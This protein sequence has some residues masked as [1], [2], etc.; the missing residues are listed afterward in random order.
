LLTEN[1]NGEYSI[2]M[3]FN[4][5]L[6]PDDLKNKVLSFSA[7]NYRIGRNY[8][9]GPVSELGPYFTHGV[10]TTREFAQH[11]ISQGG[12]KACHSI[13]SQLA[14]REFFQEVWEQKDTAIF[15]DLKHPQCPVKSSAFPAAFIS[16]DC[17]IQVIDDAVVRLYS[18]GLMHNHARLWL[19]SCICNVAKFHWF[20]PS[21]WLFY[22]LLDG[23]LASNSLSWQWV[24]GSFSN[25]KYLC[26]QTNINTYS[27]TSQRGTVIDTSYEDL[28]NIV[29]PSNWHDEIPLVLDD[30]IPTALKSNNIQPISSGRP[31]ALH[32]LWNLNPRWLAD[33]DPN[34]ILLIEPSFCKKFPMSARRWQFITNLIT[35]FP[36]LT[37]VYDE[38]TNTNLGNDPACFVQS[39]PMTKNW[40]C[41]STTRDKLFPEVKGYFP[42]FSQYWKK[43]QHYLPTLTAF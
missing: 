14:W 1:K 33:K 27:N 22:H 37:V 13:L 39:H 9:D 15:T 21:Q 16:A 34:R 4:S 40:D 35:T 43:A 20:Q 5:G 18:T 3:Y 42:S 31:I 36:S 6:L 24:A 38:F 28:W 11:L 7:E 25:K 29:P 26:N 19:A 10:I 30:Q 2:N 8:T 41:I 32:S 12:L 23:D 17:G